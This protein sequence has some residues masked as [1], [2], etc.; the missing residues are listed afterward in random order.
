[1]RRATRTQRE[2]R[3]RCLGP[4]YVLVALAAPMLGCELETGLREVDARGVSDAD[5]EVQDASVASDAS[6]AERALEF[7][8]IPAGEFDMGSTR[9]E[10]EGP[11]HRVRL[12]AFSM[13][14]FEITQRDFAAVVGSNPSEYVGEDLPV[15][16]VSWY[17]ALRF[18][19]ALSIVDGRRPAYRFREDS[20]VPDTP[21]VDWDRSADGFRLPTEAEW[22]YAARAGSAGATYAGEHP[23]GP[24]CAPDA[25]LETIGWYCDNGETGGHAAGQLRPNAFGLHDMIGNVW[26]WVWDYEPDFVPLPYEVAGPLVVDPTGRAGNGSG[27][28]VLRGGSWL[29]PNSFQRSA[30]RIA[31]VV[32]EL[33]TH[34]DFGF[35]LVGPAEAAGRV[36]LPRGLFCGE[37]ACPREPVVPDESLTDLVLVEGGSFARGPGRE[38]TVSSFLMTR[39]EV[40]QAQ[41]QAV[42]GEN[43]SHVVGPTLPVLEM[44]WYDVARFANALSRAEGLTP[45]YVI[46]EGVEDRPGQPPMPEIVT[47]VEGADGYRLPTEAEWELAARGGTSSSTHGG[48]R[49]LP[50]DR[51]GADP[52]LERIA[53]YCHN[54]GVRP[55][56]VA[57]LE[58]NAFG[59]FDML[60]N[61]AEWTWD[62]NGPLPT[63]SVLDP[64]GPAAPLG[65]RFK[66][67]RGGSFL[68]APRLQASA[69]RGSH[70]INA[71]Y[72]HHDY[73]IRLVRRATDTSVRV[74]DFD[75]G[76]FGPLVQ[77][78]GPRD[79]ASTSD[80][81]FTAQIEGGELAFVAPEAAPGP[82]LSGFL[83]LPPEA[84]PIAGP[85]AFEW[86]F[87][88]PEE[89]RAL[90]GSPALA[91][92]G[93][94][95]RGE[96]GDWI[97]GT[98]GDLWVGAAS[99]DG[100]LRS[101]IRRGA[102]ELASVP[103]EARGPVRYR[104]EKRG[105]GVQLFV[106]DGSGPFVEVGRAE[107]AVNEGRSAAVEVMHVRVLD[108]SGREILVH[109]DDFAWTFW[110]DVD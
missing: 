2:G 22:E 73:G 26:E 66:V 16:H 38:V 69:A 88:R 80:P 96:A 108:T 59:L 7:V 52:V 98:L 70:I 11:I 104:V 31:H 20:P 72:G 54:A 106:R 63:T 21:E 17:D 33:Y 1:M 101:V 95:L 50:V 58:P 71:F 35:R 76:D 61:A 8:P 41:Y 81:A 45:A 103:L 64:R 4:A 87:T 79:E 56:P 36:T 68:G 83:D 94:Y 46:R 92:A 48:E 29:Y 90:A 57:E 60:G 109:A 67:V 97:G 91:I 110:P 89:L 6:G 42:L 25:T 105:T 102:D 99:S 51:C 74:E 107:V 100:S 77:R 86:T 75:D 78:F 34:T 93:L 39:T 9:S 44:G 32:N 49:T 40:T 18:A 28:R 85:M 24:T 27:A 55:H 3:A 15:A 12:S 13:S 47:W 84:T 5:G 82:R 62:W 43:P 65:G 23:A 53:W 19:N 30:A 10:A 14:R 37:T